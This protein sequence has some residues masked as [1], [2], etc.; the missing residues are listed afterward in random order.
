MVA[1]VVM[2]DDTLSSTSVL[3]QACCMKVAEARAQVKTK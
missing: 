3:N 1:V 2:G